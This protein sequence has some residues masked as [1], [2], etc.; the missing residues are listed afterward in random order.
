MFYFMRSS[1]QPSIVGGSCESCS[2]RLL[3]KVIGTH[4]S[5][6]AMCTNTFGRSVTHLKEALAPNLLPELS[7]QFKK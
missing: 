3:S 2:R 6:G 7:V 4:C 5:E 1:L